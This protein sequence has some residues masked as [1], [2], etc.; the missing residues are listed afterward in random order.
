MKKIIA[1]TAA[2][3]MTAVIA[4]GCSSVETTASFNGMAPVVANAT[5]VAHIY[6]K[7]P[8]LYFCGLPIVTGAVAN[9]GAVSFFKDNCC[10][11]KVF[12]Q[13]NLAAEE[14]GAHGVVDASSEITSIPLFMPL[15][16]W[17]VAEVSGTAVR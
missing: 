15:F 14:L 12:F 6:S 1:L 4:G 9:P 8:G 11:D 16:Y 10:V 3:V 13:M 2:A 17:K 7:I 5:G